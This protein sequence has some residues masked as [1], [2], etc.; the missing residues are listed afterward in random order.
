M[1]L[2]KNLDSKEFEKRLQIANQHNI[3]RHTDAEDDSFSHRLRHNLPKPNGSSR[4]GRQ[5]ANSTEL[6]GHDLVT[7]MM[8]KVSRRIS[9]ILPQPHEDEEEVIRGSETPE[10]L[11]EDKVSMTWSMFKNIMAKA[12]KEQKKLTDVTS[13]ETVKVAFTKRC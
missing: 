6:P 11:E 7:T 12:L 4:T 13:A 9:E 3:V 1:N 2:Q 10:T 8:S 5:L